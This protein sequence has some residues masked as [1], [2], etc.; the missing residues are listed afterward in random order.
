MENVISLTVSH[1]LGV[2]GILFLVYCREKHTQTVQNVAQRWHKWRM[3]DENQVLV[4]LTVPPVL[5][6]FGILSLVYCREKHTHTYSNMLLRNGI[7]YGEC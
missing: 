1:V 4:S 3:L 7:I 2:F 5:S 6:V